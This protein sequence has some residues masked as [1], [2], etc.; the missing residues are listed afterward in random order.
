MENKQ[1]WKVLYEH[2]ERAATYAG[3][4]PLLSMVIIVTQLMV[5][6]VTVFHVPQICVWWGNSEPVLLS[7]PGQEWRGLGGSCVS[8]PKHQ[9]VGGKGHLHYRRE[10][11]VVENHAAVS[12]SLKAGTAQTGQEQWQNLYNGADHLPALWIQWNF[13]RQS[14]LCVLLRFTYGHMESNISR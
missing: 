1:F 14:L 4:S 2:L 11:Q 7:C 3:K 9:V 8:C 5:N 13:C 12:S 6:Y 10:L